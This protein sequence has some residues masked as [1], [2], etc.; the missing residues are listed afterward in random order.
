MRAKNFGKP[1]TDAEMIDILPE[2]PTKANALKFACRLQRNP[3][4]IEN[5]YR[6]ALKSEEEFQKTGDGSFVD[7][8]FHKQIRSIKRQLKWLS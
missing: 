8:P 5:I 6:W 1:Y 3:G 7:N 4:A 2:A